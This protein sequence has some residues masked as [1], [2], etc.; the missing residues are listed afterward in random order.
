MSYEQTTKNGYSLFEMSSMLQKAIRRGDVRHASYAASELGSSYR[1]YMWKRLLTISAEDCYGIMTKEII[2]LREA[3]TVVN[4]GKKPGTRTTIFIAKAIVLLCLAR[5]NRDA[6]YV[7]CN[8]MS[9]DRNLTEEELKEFVDTELVAEAM[10]QA[11]FDIPDYVYDVHT[12]QGKRRGKTKV[13]MYRDEN[14]ALYPHQYSLFDY[15]DFGEWYARG[16]RKGTISPHEQRKYQ[17]FRQGKDGTDPTHGGEIWP[18]D[19]YEKHQG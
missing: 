11:R 2:A 4:E 14:N 12:I 9:N 15:G 7:A 10:R 5:K 17:E 13:D 6:D 1:A 16:L 8:F 19:T 18:P 3:D